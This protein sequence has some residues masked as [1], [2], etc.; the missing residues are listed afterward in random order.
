MAREAVG[1]SERT[2]PASFPFLRVLPAIFVCVLLFLSFVS[3]FLASEKN[4]QELLRQ[5]LGIWDGKLIADRTVSR[6]ARD[7]QLE[8]GLRF[9]A[10]A[11]RCDKAS[12]IAT[13]ASSAFAFPSLGPRPS[14]VA[15][16]EEAV[17]LNSSSSTLDSR[18]AER[19]VC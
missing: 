9:L 16:S 7:S 14:R 5:G 10:H 4:R 17:A 2:S 15:V 19:T 18:L 3:S 1:W 6:C 13:R 12:E 8:G 11:N